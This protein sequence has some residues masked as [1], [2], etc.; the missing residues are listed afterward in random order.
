MEPVEITIEPVVKSQLAIEP[1][2]RVDI[3]VDPV[4]DDEID[5]SIVDILAEQH[6]IMPIE[7]IP[8][9]DDVAERRKRSSKSASPGK[10]SINRMTS[11]KSHDHHH[12]NNNN[13]NNEEEH[14]DKEASTHVDRKPPP[15]P[16]AQNRESE[17]IPATRG[18]P[19]T[20][21]EE[22]ALVLRQPNDVI[23]LRGSKV[24]L[25]V[26]Y[27]GHPEPSVKWER[28]VSRDCFVYILILSFIRIFIREAKVCQVR[29]RNLVNGMGGS[30]FFFSL[31]VTV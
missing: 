12:N 16:R 30:K 25:E 26:A 10:L 21:K 23:T 9:L 19:A 14:S 29:E 27:Q 20:G 8:T 11:I 28:A 24:V 15:S 18:I 7:P 2:E 5:Q 6:I 4:F 17:I 13:N 31:F 3:P 1:I 22:P